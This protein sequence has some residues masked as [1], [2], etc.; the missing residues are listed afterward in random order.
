MIDVTTVHK[1][2]LTSKYIAD[3]FYI[4]LNIAYALPYFYLLV[5]NLVHRV[6]LLY[7]PC[8][9]GKRKGEREKDRKK[10]KNKDYGASFPVPML[11]N[12]STEQQIAWERGWEF[13]R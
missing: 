10:E 7:A 6:I 8:G 2:L 1:L 12:W 13:K 3:L 11:G 5:R 9:V 4:L